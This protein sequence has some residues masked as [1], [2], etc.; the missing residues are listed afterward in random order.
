[1]KF[2]QIIN[3]KYTIIFI[4]II[5]FRKFVGIKNTSNNFI[6]VFGFEQCSIS[7]VPSSNTLIHVICCKQGRREQ[8]VGRGQLKYNGFPVVELQNRRRKCRFKKVFTKI[9][10]VLPAE[11]RWS[12]KK[13]K[14][15]RASHADFIVSFEWALLKLM[16]PG[17]IVPLPPSWWPWLQA[18]SMLMKIALNILNR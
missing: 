4:N 15:H 14:G 11:M 8:N 5:Y 16:G 6:A 2:K 18:H 10:T 12:P 13:K 7:S 9:L 17:V 3:L 1:M